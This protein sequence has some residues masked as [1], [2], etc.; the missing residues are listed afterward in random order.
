MRKN[1]CKVEFF[2][3]WN[4]SL[5]TFVIMVAKELYSKGQASNDEMFGWHSFEDVW[6]VFVMGMFGWHSFGDVWVAFVM[7]CLGGICFGDVWVAFVWRCLGGIR[8]IW[9]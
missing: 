8:A 9:I 6:V 2:C 5:S 7:G 1:H 4:L 3:E